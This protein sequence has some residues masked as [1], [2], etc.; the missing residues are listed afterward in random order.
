MTRGSV[1][2]RSR[3]VNVDGSRRLAEQGL[4]A[5][6]ARFIYLS[7]VKAVAE[8][9]VHPLSE[10]D[11]PMPTTVYGRTKLATERMLRDLPLQLLV[12]RPPLIV[13]PGA[14]ANLRALLRLADTPFPLPFGEIENRRSMLALS[15]LTDAIRLSLKT[16]HSTAPICWP[17]NLRSRRHGC[18]SGCAA[19][20]AGRR[21]CSMRRRSCGAW[22]RLRWSRISKSIR[23]ASRTQPVSNRSFVWSRRSKPWSPRIARRKRAD[24]SELFLRAA[25]GRG[26]RSASKNI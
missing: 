6:V 16:G 10:R 21:G 19:R 4:E 11:V 3:R 24:V 2:A 13:G 1:K 8:R 17:T 12:L 9:S 23:A 15:N 18:W 25:P 26:C 14:R 5:G 22:R 20:W 7:S